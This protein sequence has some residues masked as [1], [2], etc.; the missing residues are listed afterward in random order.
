MVI[1]TSA[2]TAIV[3]NEAE[4]EIFSRIIT[5]EPIAVISMMTFYEASIV[6]ATK[7]G[8]LRLPLSA[9]TNSFVRCRSK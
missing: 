3:T 6:T 9:S 4:R 5:A 8:T 2:I 7:I 1:D